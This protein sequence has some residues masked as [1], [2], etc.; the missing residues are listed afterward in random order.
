MRH[1]SV[2]QQLASPTLVVA[3]LV[4]LTQIK[5]VADCDE[6][7]VMAKAVQGNYQLHRN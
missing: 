2:R 1:N 3:A 7:A 4:T 5:D 6:G